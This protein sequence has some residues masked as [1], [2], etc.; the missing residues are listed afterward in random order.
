MF[1]IEMEIENFSM[2]RDEAIKIE[3]NGVEQRFHYIVLIF[4]DGMD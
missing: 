2:E 1:Y 3:T 4:Y